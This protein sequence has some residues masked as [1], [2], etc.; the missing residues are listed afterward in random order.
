MNTTSNS[1]DATIQAIDKQISLLQ[2]RKE[3]LS[4][5][6]EEKR[7]LDE[8]MQRIISGDEIKPETKKE[9]KPKQ[10]ALPRGVITLAAFEALRKAQK[11]LHL[12]E[13]VEEV[14]NSPLLRDNVPTDLERRLRGV[15]QTSEQFRNV[16]SNTFANK[17]PKLEG[18]L[19]ERLVSAAA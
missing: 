14:K 5:L 4:K 16:G 3:V 8:K 15:L 19:F 6:L 12:R 7:N 11:P 17:N 2:H 13:I 10:I 9:R 1:G 18:R